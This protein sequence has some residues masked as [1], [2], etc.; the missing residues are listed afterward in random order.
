VVSVIVPLVL[1]VLPYARGRGFNSRCLDFYLLCEPIC[2]SLRLC[3]D[4]TCT[5]LQGYAF[6]KI[7]SIIP[8]VF[9]QRPLVTL[10]GL[11]FGLNESERAMA[12]LRW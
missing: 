7:S 5:L 8:P 9:S 3:H 2:V 1:A 4:N 11:T 12:L 10:Y 6:A